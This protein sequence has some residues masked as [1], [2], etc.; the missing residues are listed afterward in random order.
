[1][2]T[3]AN[4]ESSSVSGGIWCTYD[5]NECSGCA[6]LIEISGNDCSVITGQLSGHTGHFDTGGVVMGLAAGWVSFVVSYAAVAAFGLGTIATG[7][8]GLALGAAVGIGYA[9][10]H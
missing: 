8:I 9:A 4:I 7:G 3:L 2:R 1:M 5:G 6:N 10:S